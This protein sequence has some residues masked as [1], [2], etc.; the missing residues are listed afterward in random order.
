MKYKSKRTPDAGPLRDNVILLS[1]TEVT[2]D[3]DELE[4]RCPWS[5]VAEALG[6]VDGTLYGTFSGALHRVHGQGETL[7]VI[8]RRL[9]V[10]PEGRAGS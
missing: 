5:V 10:R 9:I 1:D 6:N 8:D 7:T 4:G 2:P 3:G